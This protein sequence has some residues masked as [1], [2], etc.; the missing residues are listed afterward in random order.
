[1]CRISRSV[2]MTKLQNVG[3]V[4]VKNVPQPTAEPK[5]NNNNL[6]RVNFRADNNDQFVR[7]PRQKGPVYTQPPMLD[8]EAQIK[9]IQDA[10][11]KEKRKQNLSWGLG[12]AASVVLILALLPQAISFFRK[13]GGEKTEKFRELL[14][15][16]IS[17]DMNSSTG[18]ATPPKLRK[19]FSE[20][21]SARNADKEVDEF[22]GPLAKKVPN[23]GVVY[24]GAGVGKTY[25][26]KAFAKDIGAEYCE[27]DFSRV[28]SKYVG[29]TSVFITKDFTSA[30]ELAMKN[31][32]KPYVLVYNEVD[33]LMPD[34]SKIGSDA[35]HLIQN[36]TA[37]LDG[38]D[39]IKDVP[40]L[41]VFATTNFNPAKG[42]LDKTSLQRLG[43]VIEA[44]LPTAE[45]L[46]E[47]LNYYLQKLNKECAIEKV[48]EIKEFAKKLAKE[49]RTHRD[50]ENIVENSIM[51]Y[52][53]ALNESIKVKPDSWKERFNVNYLQQALDDLGISVN[54]IESI[55]F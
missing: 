47:S 16:P 51:K 17:N 38:L 18:N 8:R 22:I 25:G 32:N 6:Y 14:F 35:Q 11:K 4:T 50:V 52:R 34:P 54:N 26:I 48:D 49:K 10:Q 40:N 20:L 1:M 41:Y 3:N 55:G 42:G 2:V 37:F 31:P 9:Q 46:E 12:I 5:E 23:R 21:L 29:E 36:R 13:G 45:A 33:S 27:R 19:Y 53:N 44:E 28:S 7:Q 24:G 15:K 43:R 39:S 30:R